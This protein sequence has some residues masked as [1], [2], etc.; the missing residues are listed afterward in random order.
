[1]EQNAML[2][3]PPPQDL[4]CPQA[5]IHLW[6]ATFGDFTP[7]L[8]KL[9][10]LLSEDEQARA[11]RFAFD[12]H[13][14]RYIVARG[15]LRCV[16]SRYTGIPA[17]ALA[18][19]YG[20]KGK[21]S[22]DGHQ[23]RL[24]Q[25]IHFNLSHSQE[26]AVYAVTAVGP[27]GVDL[28]WVRPVENLTQISRRYF[29]QEEMALLQRYSGVAQA[30]MFFRLWTAKEAYLKAIGVGLSQIRQVQLA[31]ISVS[32]EAVS[33]EAVSPEAASPEDAIPFLES[34]SFKLGFQSGLNLDKPWQLWEFSPARQYWGSLAYA[35][36]PCPVLCWQI[37]PDF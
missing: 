37:K 34:E 8:P 19:T 3:H 1:L 9:Q 6:Q 28:E 21:P 12:L 30:Q 10:A 13:R 24:G 29:S 36:D 7:D 4:D 22:L 32:P 2:W 27:V 18:F 15:L 26:R 5:E 14:Q 25:P 20:L 23:M 11:A 35:A 16:L 33:P 17:A 31:P